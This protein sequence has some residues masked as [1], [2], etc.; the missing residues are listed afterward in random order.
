GPA[1]SGLHPGLIVAGDDHRVLAIRREDDLV[2]HLTHGSHLLICE[3]TPVSTGC[4]VLGNRSCQPAGANRSR[5][6]DM[7]D[8]LGGKDEAPSPGAPGFG[9]ICAGWSRLT[10]MS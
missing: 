2:C 8:K 6:R 5:A 3:G 10:F 9:L 7:G 1:G 4:P